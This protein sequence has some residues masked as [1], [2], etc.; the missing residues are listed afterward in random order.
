MLY[1]EPLLLPG[2]DRFHSLV[3]SQRCMHEGCGTNW[4]VW[5]W[6]VADKLDQIVRNGW[7][8]RELKRVSH[9]QVH[10]RWFSIVSKVSDLFRSHEGTRIMKFG[11][12]VDNRQQMDR[13]GESQDL[14]S[15][16]GSPSP[17]LKFLCDLYTDT[18]RL[19]RER[20]RAWHGFMA[21]PA[22]VWYEYYHAPTH[23]S[24]STILGICMCKGLAH[25]VVVFS[26]MRGLKLHRQCERRKS[27]SCW[28]RTLFAS[29][30]CCLKC[31]LCSSVSLSLCLWTLSLV[32]RLPL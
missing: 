3:H 5:A 1:L 12:F 9:Y 7:K 22:M 18:G 11:K 32:K 28:R 24:W 29:L 23:T 10:V 25:G 13:P 15:F 30:S 4:W 16:P 14:T 31:S 6:I 20:E 21:L 8:N 19:K 17:F 27:V 26:L 2:R